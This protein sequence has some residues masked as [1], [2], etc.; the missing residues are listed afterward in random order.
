MVDTIKLGKQISIIEYQRIDS[1]RCWRTRYDKQTGKPTGKYFKEAGKRNPYLFVFIAP[2][3]VPYLSAKVS[4]PTFLHGSNARILNED[5]VKESLVKLSSYVKSKAKLEFDASQCNVWEI[6]FAMD[7]KIEKNLI[8]LNMNHLSSISIPY[9]RIGRYDETTIYFNSGNART[10]CIYDKNKDC[11]DK[12]FSA[13][14]IES[15]KG[16]TRIEYRLRTTDAVKALRA[17]GKLHDRK[18]ITLLKPE[19]SNQILNPIRNQIFDALKYADEQLVIVRLTEKYGSR[20]ATNLLGHLTRVKYFGNRYYEIERLH[21]SRTSFYQ[22][23]KRCRDVGIFSLTANDG[24]H[25]H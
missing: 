23:Q 14:D 16:T 25:V 1:S 24:T 12:N 6:H 22:S 11:I 8:K 9:F 17:R 13:N 2:G 15:T 18:A 21:I 19:V 7:V 20:I 10:I 5:E 4:L 3:R